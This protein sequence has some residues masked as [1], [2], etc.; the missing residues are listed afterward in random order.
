MLC[1]VGKNKLKVESKKKE[2][3]IKMFA[4]LYHISTSDYLNSL[5]YMYFPLILKTSSKVI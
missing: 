4:I 3:N 5:F 1:K 2:R